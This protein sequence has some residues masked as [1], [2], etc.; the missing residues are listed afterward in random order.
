MKGQKDAFYHNGY[1][2]CPSQCQMC[3]KG[4]IRHR[5]KKCPTCNGNEK[6][7]RRSGI[8]QSDCTRCSWTG[9]TFS[10]NN[11]GPEENRHLQINK[12]SCIC[13]RCEGHGEIWVLLDPEGR[14]AELGSTPLLP[15]GSYGDAPDQK[16]F[17]FTVD[18]YK[19]FTKQD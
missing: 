6:S 16:S 5:K 4:Q 14:F 18:E 12:K 3:Y 19:E 15:Q 17:P 8:K 2:I 9:W 10:C 11:C 7:G 1:S 13:R